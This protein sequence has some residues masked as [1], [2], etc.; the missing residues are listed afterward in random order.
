VARIIVT[1]GNSGVGKATAAALAAAGHQMTI[2]CRTVRSAEQAAAEMAGDVEVAHLDLADLAS[3]RRF[4]DSV[5]TVDVL[6]NNAGVFGLPLTYTVDGFEAHIGTNHLGHFAL[7]CLLGAKITD[8]VISASSAIYRLGHIDLDDLHWR[9]RTYRNWG[10]Y[11]QSKLA[12]MLFTCELARR[13][14][15]AYATDPGSADTNITSDSTGVMHWLGE[16]KVVTFHLQSPPDAARAS[17]EAVTTE[18][19]S[20]SYLAPRFSQWGRPK[21]TRIRPKAC[22]PVLA[23]QLWNLSSALTGCDWPAQRPQPEPW[24]VPRSS[25]CQNPTRSPR[26]S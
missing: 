24:A 4:A 1:G 6:I 20:G 21:A 12:T 10:A 2:A 14:V 11:A 13:G 9:H 19:P 23:R 7:T 8:R 17:I 16:H 5:D 18:L 15:R 26:S 22:D 25:R 3:V